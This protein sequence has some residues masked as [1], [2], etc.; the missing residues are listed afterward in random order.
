M[1][2]LSSE[3]EFR[4]VPPLH[5]LVKFVHLHASTSYTLALLRFSS[6]PLL[7]T[8]SVNSN[9]GS[10][11]SRVHSRRDHF[12][13]VCHRVTVYVG[14]A[15]RVIAAR[16]SPDARR[17]FRK[18]PRRKGTPNLSSSTRMTLGRAFLV[19]KSARRTSN[20]YSVITRLGLAWRG[21]ITTCPPRTCLSVRRSCASSHA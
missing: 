19:R 3:E 16:T 4:N 2:R 5:S 17:R 15:T 10:R 11:F 12:R 1:P 21:A 7:R 20:E 18:G 14:R 8:L 6:P 13:P 9:D